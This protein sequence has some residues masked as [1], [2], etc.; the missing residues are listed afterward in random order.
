MD[1]AALGLTQKYLSK[2]L[3]D[4]IV[5]A[6]HQYSVDLAI[7]LGGDKERVESELLDALNFELAL[8]NVSFLFYIKRFC[9]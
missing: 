7:M 9:R 8:A 2:G 1:Q 3:D 4:K 6:Y 5:K